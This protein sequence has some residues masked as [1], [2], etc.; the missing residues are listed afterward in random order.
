MGQLTAS[1]GRAQADRWL[2]GV[3]LDTAEP[4]FGY[5]I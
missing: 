5:S 2:N 1:V 4:G 3:D